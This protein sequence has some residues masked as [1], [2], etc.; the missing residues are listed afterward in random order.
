MKEALIS[1][2]DL[3]FSYNGDHRKVLHG[4]TLDLPA[5]SITAILG[6]NGAG[7]STLV[8]ILLGILRPAGGRVSIHGKDIQDYTRRELS[9]L[10]A[11]VPQSEYTAF[12]F[13][14]LD[15]VMM[16]RAP[17]IGFLQMP[18]SEDAEITLQ[19][20]ENL[21]LTHLARRSVLELSGGEHQLV[22]IARALAQEPEMLLL[23]EPTTH[24]D[25]SNQGRILNTLTKLAEEGTTVVYTTHSPDSAARTAEYL[26]MMKE[27][28]VLSSGDV[29]SVLSAENLTRTYGV[30]V[31]VVQ[32][33]GYP[34]VLLESRES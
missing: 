30:P 27:G 26:V 16:G 21:G 15:Y 32:V 28:Q 31:R 17:H 14:V 9:H 18:T 19:H 11:F 22:L 1:I 5:G 3:E 33:D 13:S 25:L 20:L 24:L 10:I 8:H 7:K 2:R 4:M 23:D 12:D 29:N 34:V 6:P